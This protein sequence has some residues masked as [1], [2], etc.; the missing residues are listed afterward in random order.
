[1]STRRGFLQTVALAGVATGLFAASA[2]PAETNGRTAEPGF[3]VTWVG[4]PTMVITFG[5]LTIL[6]DPVLGETF[7]M[8]DPNDRVDYRTVRT[9]R[10]LT[11]VEGLDLASVDLVLLSHVHED[12]F[13]QQASASIDPATPIILP[14]ADE[15]A[16][17]AKGFTGLDA[18]R[19]GDTRRFDAGVG[20]VR[21]TAMPAR[22]SR[23]PEIAGLLGTG[24][25]Y[26]I[27]FQN[28]DRTRAVYWTGDTM[29][30]DEV[31]AAVRSRGAPDL[32][33]AHVGGVGGTGPFGRISMGAEDVIELAGAIQPR[34]VLPIHHSTY[35]FYREPIGDLAVRTEGRPYRLDV[36]TAGSTITYP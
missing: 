9:H 4:G 1:M 6:T 24:N 23:N 30:T 29:P 17:A 16:V 12:H 14:A 36:I 18:V 27:E 11:P 2:A 28:G 22:H 15:A 19:W 33:V 21:I 3:T 8:G 25:G 5:S 26:W 10:R 35:D 31:V 13:D 20:Q 32:M 34:Y 7:S